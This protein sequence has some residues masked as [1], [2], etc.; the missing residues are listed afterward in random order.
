MAHPLDIILERALAGADLTPVEG[1]QLLLQQDE[2]AIAAIREAADTLRQQQVG[3]TVTYVVNRNIN[4][5]NIC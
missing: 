2:G 1:V 5:T 4:F 3:D